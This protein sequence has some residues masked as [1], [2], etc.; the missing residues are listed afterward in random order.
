M[1]WYLGEGQRSFIHHQNASLIGT[2]IPEAIARAI[3]TD[4]DCMIEHP[5]NWN[6]LGFQLRCHGIGELVASV[7]GCCVD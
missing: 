7:R 3:I 6:K 4:G 1:G 5:G 2:G